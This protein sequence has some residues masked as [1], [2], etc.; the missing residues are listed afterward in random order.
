MTA[1][2]N[3]ECLVV[4]GGLA[5]AMAALRLAA[6]GRDVLLVEKERG[7]HDKV[8]GEFLSP[9]AVHYLRAAGVDPVELG[10][11]SVDRLRVSVASRT[12]AVDLPF[13]AL[14]LS[15][16]V[17]DEALLARA[18]D[19]GCRM[20]RGSAVA[21]LMRHDHRWIARL[22]SGATVLAD[23]VFLA[24]GKH[25]LRGWARAAGRQNDLVGF[26]LHGRLAPEPTNA[27][28]GGME[29]FLFRDGYGGLSLVEDGMANLCLVVRKARLQRLGGWPALL[30]TLLAEC[31]ALRTLLKDAQPLWERPLAI[32][33]IPY[34]Y[35]APRAAA[36]Q[37]GLWPVGDQIA[38]IP[39]FT[40]DG[41]SI[42][43]H[44]A[45]L[46]AACFLAGETPD[47]YRA[48]LA[49]QLQRGMTLATA[50]SRA[51]VTRGGRT[52]APALLTMAPGLLRSIAVRTR[53]PA[54][55]LRS[56]P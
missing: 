18:A 24:T 26:K 41:M 6:A 20:L 40:G 47:A 23:H 50:L 55:A 7:A 16:S 29:L 9:E 19:H 4:G 28:R 17:L 14:S 33:S 54:E 3:S 27:L 2:H 11:E 38:V 12:V 44:S 51:M 39:S 32:S 35:L 48:R 45:S 52:L 46:A 56:A 31:A 22:S 53:I 43:L 15:R 10:A 8:C 25:D 49:T 37:D 30:R 21:S 13:S 42:A 1:M 34:G 5:G 36:G